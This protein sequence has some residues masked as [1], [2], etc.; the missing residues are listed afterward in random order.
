MIGVGLSEVR[1]VEHRLRQLDDVKHYA[2]MA[3]ALTG[4]V[5]L[6][7]CLFALAQACEFLLQLQHVFVG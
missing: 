1:F 3:A 4:K 7:H 6:R 5:L 2:S